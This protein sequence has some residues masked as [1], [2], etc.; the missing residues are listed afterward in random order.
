MRS[1]SWSQIQNTWRNIRRHLL[2]KKIWKKFRCL[3][4]LIWKRRQHLFI[5]QNF[6]W[7]V[8]RW[9]T[10]IFIRMGSFIWPCCLILRTFRQRTFRILAYWRRYLAMWIQKIIPMRILQMRWTS[11]PEESAVRSVCIRAWRIKM[12]IRWN[13]RCAPR[14]YMTN[15]RKQLHWWKK[16]FSP[17]T[18]MMKSVCMR[19]LPSWNQD[20]R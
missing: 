18:L 3:R 13:L 16:C 11:I 5:I 10:M 2:Q 6:Q 7:K 15:C 9:Y 12:I 4:A 17:Q 19:L 20:F 14:H 1:E 8:S